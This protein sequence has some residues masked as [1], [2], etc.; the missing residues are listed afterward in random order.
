MAK[1]GVDSKVFIEG[2]KSGDVGVVEDRF[3]EIPGAVGS[4][5]E[6]V[7]VPEDVGVGFWD[8]E[9]V[10]VGIEKAIAVEIN[11]KFWHQVAV[12]EKVVF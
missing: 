2:P 9:F 12:C 3:F 4:K 8:E 5:A 7:E 11:G 1:F 10:G 6:I